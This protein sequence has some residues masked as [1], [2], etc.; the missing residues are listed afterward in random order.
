MMMKSYYLEDGLVQFSS[1]CIKLI[2]NNN[3]L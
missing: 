1:G 3:E 2:N